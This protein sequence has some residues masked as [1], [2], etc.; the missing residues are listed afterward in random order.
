MKR[1]MC[2]WLAVCVSVTALFCAPAV[3]AEQA[4][5]RVTWGDPNGDGTV[6][7]ADALVALRCAV[8]KLAPGGLVLSA[9]DVDCSDVVNAADALQMLKTAVGKQTAFDPVGMRGNTYLI[10]TAYP[11]RYSEDT[12]YG[13]AMLQAIAN[14]EAALGVTIEVQTLEADDPLWMYDLLELPAHQCRNYARSGAV[15]DFAQNAALSD[16]VRTG[17]SALACAMGDGQYGAGSPAMGANAMGLAI[18]GDLLARY[19]PTAYAALGD[20]F[21]DGTWTWEALDALIAEYRTNKPRSAVLISNTN[22]IG[23]AI[24][25]NAGYEVAFLPDGTGAVCSIA[26]PEGIQAMEYI[27]GM[28]NSGAWQYENNVNEMAAMFREQQVPMAVYYLSEAGAWAWDAD[29]TLTAMPFPKGPKQQDYVMSTFNAAVFTCPAAQTEPA[30]GTALVLNALAEADAALAA[31]QTADMAERGF[32]RAG[33]AV[34]AWAA[35]HTSPDF[36]TG[37]F[38]GAVGG[39]VDGSVLTPSQ[40]PATALPRIADLI[41]QEVDAYY[42]MFYRR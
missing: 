35:A 22:I 11:S 20:Q 7:A 30:N 14:A 15:R 9:C 32:D 2:I 6:N 40:K 28:Y 25:S 26:S 10:G 19:A 21:E 23:Q 18:N 12:A 36:S 1:W 5:P 24:V 39:P 4:Q 34:F 41:Q 31:A 38:D 3:R 16:V 13:R 29:F 17:A 42:G 33:Q 27:K 37:P 8:G